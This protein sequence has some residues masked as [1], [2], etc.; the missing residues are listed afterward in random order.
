MGD[1][2]QAAPW[3]T[4]SIKGC[5]KF[6]NRVYDMKEFLKEGSIR[7]DFEV[8]INKLIKKVSEDIETMK[9]NTAIAAMMSFVNEIYNSKEI[10]KEEFKIFLTLLNPFAPHITEEL[11]SLIGFKTQ[12]ANEKWPTYDIEKC[13][14]KT[15]EIVVQLNGKVKHKILVAKD[16]S[17]EEIL[18]LIEKDEKTKDILK[19]KQI[20]KTI[21]VLNKLVN[22][23]VKN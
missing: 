12:I 20:L 21:V 4:A 2:E 23:V 14:D 9:F 16:L 13:I 11:F 19:D 22:F 3:D 5:K 15:V 10:T 17:K 18:D 1:F 8:L 6:L 7:K